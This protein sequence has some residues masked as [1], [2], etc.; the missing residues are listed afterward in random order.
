MVE[1]RMW[2][3][4][5]PVTAEMVAAEVGVDLETHRIRLDSVDY[6]HVDM[7]S[8]YA[9]ASS[10]NASADVWRIRYAWWHP[11]FRNVRDRDATVIQFQS[12][13][14]C[15]GE[16]WATCS[17]YLLRARLTEAEVEALLSLL[18]AGILP[19]RTFFEEM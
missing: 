2:D 16:G 6:E 15:G 14:L 13:G 8:S 11:R 17:R 7:V 5:R 19:E 3:A 12:G 1:R 10:H 9:L 4:D 18:E